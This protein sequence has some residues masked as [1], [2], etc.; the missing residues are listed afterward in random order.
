MQWYN[1]MLERHEREIQNKLEEANEKLARK[2]HNHI[3]NPAPH[4]S[5]MREN[6]RRQFGK[7]AASPESIM[8]ASSSS[9]NRK[10]EL[11]SDDEEKGG[12]GGIA[13]KERIVSVTPGRG[14]SLRPDP[15]K[16]GDT[17][18]V[19]YIA[20][21]AVRG[22][23]PS[24]PVRERTKLLRKN[25]SPPKLIFRPTQGP[26]QFCHQASQ[27]IRWTEA[28][29]SNLHACSEEE[30]PKQTV[31]IQFEP[32]QPQKTIV[33]AGNNAGLRIGISS[34]TMSVKLISEKC[35]GLFMH[36]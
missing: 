34:P 28:P 26:R 22:F 7:D 2:F 20:V 11:D 27:T 1:D 6:F 9:A 33:I 19:G 31:W 36:S 35:T 21:F 8:M 25:H 15:P 18:M 32:R 5:R 12:G 29:A 13:L 16:V 14:V 24:P 3:D 4:A 30:T 23:K 10:E 17:W